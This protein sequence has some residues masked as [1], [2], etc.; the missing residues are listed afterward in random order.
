LL[1]S[2]LAL[3]IRLRRLRRLHVHA[4]LSHSALSARNSSV[5]AGRPI[6]YPCA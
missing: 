2:Q 3:G 5:G 4:R 6:Q 1:L